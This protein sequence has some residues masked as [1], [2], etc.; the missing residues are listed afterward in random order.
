LLSLSINGKKFL[1]RI[2]LFKTGK[3]EK[4]L[5]KNQGRLKSV[6][7]WC[8]EN[9]KSIAKIVAAAVVITGRDS[10]G[11]DRRYI[12]SHTGR[13]I[14]GSI[15]RR[16]DRGSGW[17][18]SRCDKWRI[19]SGRI[20]GRSIER[21][22]FRSGDRSGMCRA[23]CLGA[24]AGKSIQ[25]MSTVGKAINVTS[26]VTAALSFGMDG[27]DMLAMGISL[28]DPSNALVEFNRKLHSN[29]LYNGFQ[30]AVN[31]LAVF[32]AGAA[33][34][35]KCF[36]AGTMILTVAGLVAIENIKAGTR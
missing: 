24:L 16:I 9:W 35:M 3:R 21:S 29:A 33:S 15:G 18:N 25:C 11:I 23:W 4:R 34:T 17:R 27:F 13:S 2:L 5:G 26:K 12:G 6:A 8:K 10:G 20:C 32:S 14:L 36:V 31:A 22:D 7:E 30:I 28:F 1:Q 19:V